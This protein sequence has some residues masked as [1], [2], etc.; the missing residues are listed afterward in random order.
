[1]I[2]SGVSALLLILRTAL[3]DRTLQAELPGY[4]EYARRVRYRLLPGVW[5][6]EARMCDVRCTMCDA[7][8]SGDG[9][10]A[11][12]RVGGCDLKAVEL[13]GHL[14]LRLLRRSEDEE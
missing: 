5:W 4:A 6:V 11:P 1:M 14:D 2:A 12:R 8:F 7:V 10:P 13:V 9:E 3:E